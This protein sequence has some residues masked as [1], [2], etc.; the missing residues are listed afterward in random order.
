MTEPAPT[1]TSAEPVLPGHKVWTLR[2]GLIGGLLLVV[3]GLAA[4]G[5]YLAAN[6]DGSDFA[7]QS[8]LSNTVGFALIYVGLIFGLPLAATAWQGLRRRPSPPVG[9]P[10]WA[11]VALLALALLLGQL[12]LSFELATSFLFPPLHA[13]S[14]SLPPILLLGAVALALRDRLA[15]VTRRQ[16]IVSLS[17]GAILA[18]GLAF[19]LEVA[20]VAVGVVVGAVFIALQPGGLVQLESLFWQ[21]QDG[22]MPF[23]QADL[24]DLLQNPLAVAALVIGLAGVAPLIEEGAKG[25][26]VP[27]LGRWYELTLTRGWLWG[28]TAGAGFAITESLFNSTVGLDLWLPIVVMRAGTAVLHCTTAGLTGLGWAQARRQ[29]NLWPAGRNF[30][31]ALLTHGTWNAFTAMLVVASTQI[32]GP[33]FS[34]AGPALIVLVSLGGLVFLGLVVLVSLIAITYHLRKQA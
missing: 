15:G 30:G 3:L 10:L 18:T 13:L 20:M 19:G 6:P 21:L 26:V 33:G 4:G 2:L 34:A 16:A 1:P 31:L 17:V 8:T 9:F 5:L 11:G 29:G 25:L 23:D 7:L 24:V 14:T 22:R 28:L 12:V 32:T 27:L